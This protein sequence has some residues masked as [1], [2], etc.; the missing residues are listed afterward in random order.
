MARLRGGRE[1]PG[2]MVEANSVEKVAE[3]YVKGYFGGGK[4]EA[5]EIWQAWR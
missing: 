4:E 5:M 3:W 1:A 2:A